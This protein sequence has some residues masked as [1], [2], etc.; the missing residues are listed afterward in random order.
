M[1]ITTTPEETMANATLTSWDISISIIPKVTGMLSLMGSAL[2]IHDGI[3]ILR[4]TL[5]GLV[6]STY[7]R[8]LVSMSAFD[9]ISSMCNFL[10]TW[11]SPRGTPGAFQ[12]VGTQGT[13]TAQGFF[14]EVGNITVVLYNAMLCVYQVLS[15][16]KGWKE[17]YLSNIQ[18]VFHVIPILVGLTMGIMGL[19]FSIFGPAQHMCWFVTDPPGGLFRTIHFG[20]IWSAITYVSVGMLLIYWDVRTE[21]RAME[22]FRY[23]R[24]VDMTPEELRKKRK[25]ER[26]SGNAWKVA[27][28]AGLF[29]VAM[30]LT[31][32]FPTV[33]Y[34]CSTR[35]VPS[36]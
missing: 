16:R 14:S 4:R 17:Y 13:C 34:N 27:E 29:V 7:H 35:L 3:R 10:S 5:N 26:R 15:I 23:R 33:S 24:N 22:K 9:I 28:R 2:I 12:A 31:W 1:N 8:I 36:Y 25:A 6:P 18:W 19:V 21:D 20:I 32:T 30:Y 11:P